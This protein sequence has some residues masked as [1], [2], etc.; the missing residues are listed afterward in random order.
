[1][2]RQIFAHFQHE[3]NALCAA[4]ICDLMRIGNDCSRTVGECRARQLGRCEHRAFDMDMSVDESRADCAAGNVLGLVGVRIGII[5]DS[6]DDIILNQDVFADRFPCKYV[7]DCSVLEQCFHFAPHK[8]A[9][10]PPEAGCPQSFH[11]PTDE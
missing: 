10:I 7:D 9:D 1:M 3:I 4:D 6:E 2:H 8:N 11:S 5:P